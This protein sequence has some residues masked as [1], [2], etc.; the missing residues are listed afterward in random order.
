[1]MQI[2]Q[3]N[4]RANVEMD[5]IEIG[6]SSKE[7]WYAHARFM[8][9]RLKAMIQEYTIY[10]VEDTAPIA[11][12]NWYNNIRGPTGNQILSQLEYEMSLAYDYVI[13]RYNNRYSDNDY[14]SPQVYFNSEFKFFTGK[15]VDF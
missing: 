10:G 6:P 11:I 4:E 2:I 9:P 8:V 3:S 14:I 1:M 5:N 15:I 13:N 12:P 7:E